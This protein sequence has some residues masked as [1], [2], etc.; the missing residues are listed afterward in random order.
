MPR[1]VFPNG[2][3]GPVDLTESVVLGRSVKHANVVL[4]DNRLSRAHCRIEPSD[5]GWTVIDLESQNGTFLNGRRI[6]QS[7]L[8]PG[9]V[10]KLGAVEVDFEV[11]SGP[12]GETVMKGVQSANLPPENADLSLEEPDAVSDD[13]APAPVAPDG[14]VTL[15]AP[16]AL[17]V[18]KGSLTERVFPLTKEVF[19]VGRK[20]HNDIVLEGDGKASGEHARFTAKDGQYHVQDLGSTNGTMY[21]GRDI[22]RRSGQPYAEAQRLQDGDR[23]LLANIELLLRIAPVSG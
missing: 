22:T 2:E 16:A 15:L 10:I 12:G 9:D 20:R 3:S 19:N 17:V 23:L 21:N 7:M 13:S 8:K 6:K 14:T 18:L 5:D 1:L 4:D 11:N